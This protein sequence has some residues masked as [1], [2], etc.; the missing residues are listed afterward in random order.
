MDDK[1]KAD[2]EAGVPMVIVH[3]DKDGN[4]TS[5]EAFNLENIS[6]TEWQMQSLARTALEGCKRFYA[7]PDNVKKFEEWKEKRDAGAKRQ[8]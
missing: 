2:I 5:Q 6:L 7:D 1:T 3:W 4:V 8:K